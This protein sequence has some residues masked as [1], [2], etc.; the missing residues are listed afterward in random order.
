MSGD[1]QANCQAEI[2]SLL[3]KGAIEEIT[4]GSAGFV[5]QRKWVDL[6]RL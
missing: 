6:G 3:K 4:D 5:Y 1:M 2:D